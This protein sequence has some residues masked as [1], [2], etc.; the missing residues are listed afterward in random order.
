MSDPAAIDWNVLIAAGTTLA[1]GL[2]LWLKARAT[3]RKL[4][5]TRAAAENGHALREQ[6]V[7]EN[8]T[9]RQSLT[10]TQ[11]QRDVYRDIVQYVRSRPEPVIRA[12]LA[13]YE[14]RRR[15][16]TYDP[17]AAAPI[18]PAV[19]AAAPATIPLW[20]RWLAGLAGAALLSYGAWRLRGER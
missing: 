11:A 6:L 15:V 17:A 3:D 13:A 18:A 8:A 1:T 10:A 14:D 7:A 16:A 4:E 12:A 2:G 5:E 20:A 19:G 9:L